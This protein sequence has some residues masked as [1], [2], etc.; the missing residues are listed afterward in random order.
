MRS[1]TVVVT[2]F[3]VVVKI[4]QVLIQFPPGSFHRAH[5]PGESEQLTFTDLETIWLLGF[6]VSLPLVERICRNQAPAGFQRIAERRLGARRFRSGIDHPCSTR[7]VRR[8]RWNE[9]PAHQRQF[10]DGLLGMLANHRNGL[11]RRN[12]E[13]R[14]PVFLTGDGIEIFFDD[15][16]SPTQFVAAAHREIMADRQRWCRCENIPA[17]VR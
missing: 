12:V 14:A 6:P 2:A 13:A 4:E 17:C 15:L 9:S 8:P 11:G 16:L 1:W 10:A 7:R 3:A 5:S